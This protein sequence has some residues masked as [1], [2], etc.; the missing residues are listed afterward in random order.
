V[1][2]AEDQ[3][4]VQ[5]LGSD[6]ADEPFGVGVGLRRPD[7]CPDHPDP[8]ALEDLVEGDAEL[9]VAG[10]GLGSASAPRHP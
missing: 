2:A 7:R 10:R 6:G 9:A 4:P 1:A 5:T 8:F 3:Q